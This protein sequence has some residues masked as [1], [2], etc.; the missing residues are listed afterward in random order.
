MKKFSP[1]ARRRIFYFLSTYFPYTF[2]PGVVDRLRYVG[3][4][5]LGKLACARPCLNPSDEAS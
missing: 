4:C 1:F 2:L 5:T 3:G